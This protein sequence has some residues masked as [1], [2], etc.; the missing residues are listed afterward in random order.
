VP[1]DDARDLRAAAYE[2]L[3][4][5]QLRAQDEANRHSAQVILSRLFQHYRPASVLDVGCGLGTWLAVAVELGVADVCGIEGTWLDRRLARVPEQFILAADLE[6]GFALGRRFD[7]VVCLE[8]AEHL[9]AAA[10]ER[11]VAALVAHADVILFS[12][13][14]PYQGGHHHVNEQ[15]ADYW[16]K[17][18]AAHDYQVV[19]WLRRGLWDD[20]SILWWLRQNA[21]VYARRAL[22]GPGGPFADLVDRAGPL[23]I[24][25]PDVYLDRLQTAL[26]SLEEHN[27]LV[28]LLNTGTLFSVTR[29]ANGQL[30]IQRVS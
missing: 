9:S 25:H 2:D 14:I 23:S 24:V 12:A 4:Q 8:V 3:H 15:F 29:Q 30:T 22:C 21:M 1:K 18:F 27:K 13:A 19:D 6:A 17:R 11:F 5:R 20:A 28:A 10:A 16:Q 7:L 26:R